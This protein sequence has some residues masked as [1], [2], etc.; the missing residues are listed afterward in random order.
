MH[1]NKDNRGH[2]LTV[3][4]KRAMTPMLATPTALAMLMHGALLL[5]V[6]CC[7]WAY[8]GM[9]RRE[10]RVEIVN[11][12]ANRR[13]SEEGEEAAGA[14]R[15][16]GNYEPSNTTRREAA[17]GYDIGSG[18]TDDDGGEEYVIIGNANAN[19]RRTMNNRQLGESR[20]GG[21]SIA[22]LSVI[23]PMK[24]I[25]EHTMRNLRSH[26][27]T[28]YAGGIE[29]IIVVQGADDPAYDAILKEQQAGAHVRPGL[30]LRLIVA[31]LAA[32]TSQKVHNMLAGLSAS[33]NTDFVLFLDDDV[34]THPGTVQDQI[35]A[36][37]CVADFPVDAQT[38]ACTNTN[39]LR[40]SGAGGSP[41]TCCSNPGSDP[42]RPAVTTVHTTG[43][44]RAAH[45]RRR[46]RMTCSHT[47][48][49]SDPTA[50]RCTTSLWSSASAEVT[51]AVRHTVGACF[52][53]GTSSCATNTASSRAGGIMA[54]RMT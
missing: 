4:A 49:R 47:T 17:V 44:T 35:D 48:R 11:A 54:I 42:V 32:T 13:R 53:T 43:T 30:Q 2:D 16:V 36:I 27:A 20:R 37:R 25:R 45:S 9:K 5:A 24:G 39:T 40:G 26:M 8:S 38:K 14:D 34:Q 21:R 6:L 29:I 22:Q 31:G 10:K 51:E 1:T 3:E 46:I 28:E 23:I 18:G 15:S 50:F 7:G 52:S 33:S 19:M 41:E 12:G